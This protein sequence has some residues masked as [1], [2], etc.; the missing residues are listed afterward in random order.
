MTDLL[1]DCHQHVGYLSYLA[2]RDAAR[3]PTTADDSDG[4]AEAALRASLMTD[5]SISHS[6]VMPAFEYRTDDGARSV[7]T[8]NDAVIDYVQSNEFAL[9]G[10]GILDPLT[11]GDAVG[12]EM[13]RLR[14]SPGIV[15]IAW[16]NRFQRLAIDAPAVYAAVAAS[17]PD[18]FV[19]AFHCV[20][21]SGMEAPWRLEPLV[22]TFPDHRFLVLSAMGSP[23]NCAQ[24][25]E[26]CTRRNNIWLDLGVVCPVGLWIE[27]FVQRIGSRRLVF[28]TDMYT[29]PVSFRHNYALGQLQS[30]LLSKDQKTDIMHRNALAL[31]KL[32]V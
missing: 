12:A 23:A 7:T 25:L 11:M 27:K 4:Q 6:L 2:D 18:D 29:A 20:G 14:A 10:F 24:M 15:G 17:D 5:M 3:R 28:G 19:W 22:A 1:I 8:A 30:A 16:H 31:F 9:A 32:S 21:E 13:A 26:I